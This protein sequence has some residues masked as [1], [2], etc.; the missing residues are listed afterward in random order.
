MAKQN[1]AGP[2]SAGPGSGS[3]QE[4][5]QSSQE[6]QLDLP[7]GFVQFNPQSDRVTNVHQPENLDESI[8]LFLEAEKKRIDVLH[9]EFSQ[10]TV[11]RPIVSSNLEQTMDMGQF[12]EK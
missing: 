2:S 5:P 12:L 1:S 11:E 3:N 9:S 6:K 4:R 7:E 10:T 8:N